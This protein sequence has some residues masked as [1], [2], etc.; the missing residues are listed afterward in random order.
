MA[1]NEI[2]FYESKLEWKSGKEGDLSVAALPAITVGAPP[3]FNGREGVWSPEHLF[4]ASVNSCFMLTLLAI[5]ENSR[6]PLHSYR[7][8]ASGK[9]EKAQGGGFQ[10]TEVIIKPTVVIASAQD[11]AR[12]SRILEKAKQ[13]CFITNSIRS[14]VKLEPQVYH[15][16]SQTVPCSLGETPSSGGDKTGE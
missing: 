14:S 12:V 6:L 1:E 15:R 5:A 13:N 2:F 10:I 3:E 4:V 7:A 11:L 9:L 16:Q 8:T